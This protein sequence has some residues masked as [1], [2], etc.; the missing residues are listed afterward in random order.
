V[1]E[2][3]VIK[4]GQIVMNYEKEKDTLPEVLYENYGFTIKIDSQ[5]RCIGFKGSGLCVAVLQVL[6]G[7]PTSLQGKIAQNIVVSGGPAHLPKLV[8][9]MNHELRKIL[10]I[11][12][13]QRVEHP[14]I[15]SYVGV[16]VMCESGLAGATLENYDTRG[17]NCAWT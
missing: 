2:D 11:A 17:V 1:A 9:R 6:N 7:C 10:P 5:L 4:H 13:V 8:E 15:G 16:T 14:E 12:N 3:I